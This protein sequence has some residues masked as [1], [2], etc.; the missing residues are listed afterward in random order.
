MR[1]LLVRRPARSRPVETQRRRPTG[2]A[3]RAAGA[4]AAP[5]CGASSCPSWRP[6]SAACRASRACRV[7]P[8]LFEH[9]VQVR[10]RVLDVDV[11]ALTCARL[12]GEH[13][14]AVDA[15]EVPIRELVVLL[16]LVARLVVDAEVPLRVLAPSVL[17]EELVLLRGRRLVLAPV[18]TLVEDDLALRGQLLRVVERLAV[19]PDSHSVHL[20]ASGLRLSAF[21]RCSFSNVSWR[22]AAALDGT[23]N[24]GPRPAHDP[25]T[26]SRPPRIKGLP[27]RGSYEPGGV[28]A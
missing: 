26:R 3:Q 10:R 18:V 23:T 5:P 8:H 15:L 14:A 19:E 24:T 9:A 20:Q 1:P 25:G 28:Y 6:S 22:F 11:F 4:A 7:R 16:C 27:E 17:R 12:G 2:P 13:A 21:G